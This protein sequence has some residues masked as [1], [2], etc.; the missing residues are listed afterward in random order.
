VVAVLAPRDLTGRADLAW[1]ATAAAEM[2]ATD[3]TSAPGTRVV[4]PERVAR[5]ARDLDLA[6]ADVTAPEVLARVR[7]ALGADYVVTGTYAA[8]GGD[9]AA[10]VRFDLTVLDAK[11]GS[12]RARAGAT[13]ASASLFDVID[14]AS[15]DLRVAMGGTEPTAAQVGEARAASPSSPEAIRLYSEGIASLRAGKAVDALP[16]F[17]RAGRL[18]PDSPYVAW[19]TGLALRRLGRDNDSLPLLK[20]AFDLRGPLSREDQLRIEAAYREATHDL[21]AAIECFRTLF[22]FFPD[23]IDHGLSYARALAN[24]GRPSEAW[25]PLE[26]LRR[27]PPPDSN[28][29]R[30]ELQSSANAGREG[31]TQRRESFARAAVAKAEALGLS[32]FLIEA[33][34]QLAQTLQYKGDLDGSL[35]EYQR[36]L[37]LATKLGD[38]G[39]EAGALTAIA[40]VYQAKGDFARAYPLYDDAL[41]RTRAL[42]DLYRLAGILNMRAI[43]KYTQGDLEGSR[44]DWLEAG[45]QYEAIGDREGVGH[46]TGNVANAY[47]DAGDLPRSQAT[48]EKAL[49]ILREIGNRSGVSEELCNLVELSI[50]RGALDAAARWQ[51][52]LETT[53][54]LLKRQLF[55]GATRELRAMLARQTDD[56]ATAQSGADEARTTFAAMGAQPFTTDAELFV[57]ELAL[58][59]GDATRA[60]SAARASAAWY[61]KSAVAGSL[62]VAHALVARA[63]AAQG[64]GAEALEAADR[65]TAAASRTARVVSKLEAE[66]AR[67]VALAANGQADKAVAV[68]EAAIGLARSKGFVW[69]ELELRLARVKIRGN[70]TERGALASDARARGFTRIARLATAD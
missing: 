32:S 27:L 4:P 41:A 57:A 50:Q 64:K 20:K 29:V 14:R 11:D 30:I 26:S 10:Q 3:L 22:G 35:P 68:L 17:E 15:T 8:V 39:F 53:S 63:L 60:E 34:M 55:T 9:R 67:G 38:Q 46:T 52:E 18:A 62:P 45:R 49:G 1:V 28:D 33:H 48:H 6:R 44:V 13:G 19:Q 5:A 56:A 42:G 16:L 58:D 70:A 66:R 2:L 61:E 65:A 23:S 21:P 7:G 40:D 43:A 51:A 12:A 25:A 69:Q 24:A 31:D 47:Q 37:D 54:A 36:A 59:R